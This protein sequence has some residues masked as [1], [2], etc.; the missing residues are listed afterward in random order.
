MTI[1]FELIILTRDYCHSDITSI[2]QNDRASQ[3][4]SQTK[5]QINVVVILDGSICDIHRFYARIRHDEYFK[6]QRTSKAIFGIISNLLLLGI[7]VVY[8]R[9]KAP[10]P[11]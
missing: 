5:A 1:Y 4:S 8:S 7:H 11:F 3:S 9:L 2:H 10:S 6:N